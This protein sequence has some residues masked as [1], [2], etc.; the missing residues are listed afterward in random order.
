MEAERQAQI[1]DNRVSGAAIA[2]YKR[3]RKLVLHE[4]YGLPPGLPMDELIS[5]VKKRMGDY[6]PRE[7]DLIQIITEYKK[8]L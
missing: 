7:E 4:T 3:T 5:V 8:T 6:K 1:Y 2:R